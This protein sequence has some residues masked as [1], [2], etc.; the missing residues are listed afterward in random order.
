MN[1]DGKR[2]H[3][4]I[5]TF[6]KIS[7]QSDRVLSPSARGSDFYQGIILD[8]NIILPENE[9][10]II[11]DYTLQNNGTTAKKI[12]LY[13]R[14]RLY[15]GNEGKLQIEPFGDYQGYR[16]SNPNTN[17]E[18]YLIS[19]GGEYA[20]AYSN[21]HSQY[22][23][24]NF[25]TNMDP[26]RYIQFTNL[27][28]YWKDKLIDVD[29]VVHLY[30]TFTPNLQIKQSPNVIMNTPIEDTYPVKH[31]LLLEGRC[32]GYEN[33]Q[34]IALYYQYN[35]GQVVKLNEFNVS[36]ELR[37]IDFSFEL[38]LESYRTSRIINVWAVTKDAIITNYF[39]KFLCTGRKP[40]LYIITP[41]KQLYY[42]DSTIYVDFVGNSD[43]YA[44]LYYNVD[45]KYYSSFKY[46]NDGFRNLTYLGYFQRWDIYEGKHNITLYIKDDYH[47]SESF[48]YEFDV[49]TKP[50]PSLSLLNGF[51][52]NSRY[53]NYY[54]NISIPISMKGGTVGENITH[55][56][57]ERM[58]EMFS[59]LYTVLITMEQTRYLHIILN[60]PILL[61][62]I[63]IIGL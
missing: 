28:I 16:Y 55:Y 58:K 59:P 42:K 26:R 53:Y 8:T 31:N 19:R 22:Y 1:Y 20:N 13:F 39:S 4:G 62:I 7:G 27:L 56:G 38:I 11:L 33:G 49:I 17:E 44:Y 30:V 5:K 18:M 37:T 29:E 63:P 3:Q 46:I 41:P 45:N 51:Q 21:Y 43:M 47:Y 6:W 57:S 25:Y 34:T 15:F 54:Q 32:E 2:I 10:K 23:E 36:E 12:D 14:T 48:Y 61:Q 52:G 40:V 50:R 35:W 24:Y 9:D 60:Y